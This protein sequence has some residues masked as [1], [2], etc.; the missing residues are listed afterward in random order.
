MKK[1]IFFLITFLAFILVGTFSTYFWWKN[2]SEAVSKTSSQRLDFL[3]LKGQTAENIA[4]ELYKKGLIRNPKVFK[5]YVQLKGLSGKIQAGRYSLSPNLSLIEIVDQ[6]VKGPRDVWVTI[7]EGLRREEVVERLIKGLSKEAEE[8]DKFRQD[9]LALTE[10]SEG[11]LFPDTY[12]FSREA[13]ASLVVSTLKN[14]FTKKVQGLEDKISASRLSF[15]DLVILA[16]IVE[17]EAREDEERR[18]VAGILLK[19]LE[20]GMPLQ[21]DATV[22]YAVASIKCKVE[23]KDCE[24]WWPILIREDLKVDSQYNTYKYPGLPPNP[25]TNPGLSSIEAVVSPI[26]TDYL[27]YLHDPQGNVH[28]AKTLEEHNE[29]VRKYL[30]K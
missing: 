20:I 26:E 16:S 2:E 22:Q 14:N 17:R 6:L 10:D 18:V 8:E 25:I 30:G 15:R 4:Q 13:D 28:Y 1:S 21:A 24:N 29:N 5:F 7:P 27:Y 3:I 23:S 19:R 9:F 12:L 11:F